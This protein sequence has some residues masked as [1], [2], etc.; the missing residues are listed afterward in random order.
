MLELDLIG[1]TFTLSESDAHWIHAQARAASGNSL[2]ARDLATRLQSLEPA[3]ERKRLVLTRPESNALARLL[4]VS[5]QPP[6][7]CGELRTALSQLLSS[8]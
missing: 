8:R 1:H 4:K 6:Q 5:D 3:A 7:A 2:G